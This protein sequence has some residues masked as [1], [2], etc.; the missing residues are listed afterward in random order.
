MRVGIEPKPISVL[1]LGLCIATGGWL[2]FS[3][4]QTPLQDEVSVRSNTYWPR[5]R[6]T[7]KVDSRLVEVGVVVR[8]R[9]GRTV[10]GLSRDNFA[11]IDAGKKREITAFSRETS[12]RA[13]SVIPRAQAATA[14]PAV[15]QAP[16]RFV[17]LLFDDLTI[18]A[19][20]LVQV[21]TAAL[22]FVREGLSAGDLLGIFTISKEQILPFTRNVPEMIE[23]IDKFNSSPRIPDGGICP[24]LTPY[25]AY[26]IA[27]KL[28]PLT[29]ELKTA[30]Y[31]RCRSFPD[32]RIR[33]AT[34]PTSA[35]GGDWVSNLAEVMWGQIY[36]LSRAALSTI[37]DI[38]EYLG[39][40]TGKRMILLASSGF[41][42]QTLEHEQD[43]IVRNALR[44]QVVINALDARGLY[45]QDPVESS[46][47]SDMQ[48][49]I[50]AASLGT[51]QKDRGKDAMANLALS[52][53]GLFFH[54]N[55]DLTLGFRELGVLPEVSYLL[56]YTPDEPLNGKYHKLKVSVKS[57]DRYSVQARPGY[58]AVA[59]PAQNLL[60][61]QRSIDQEFSGTD[62]KTEL[63]V[64][65]AEI[66]P[67]SENGKPALDV[68]LHIDVGRMDLDQAGDTRTRK[69]TWI[70]GL[71]D[72]AGNFIVGSENAIEMALK[73]PT[74][75][76]M[77]ANG[78]NITITLKA[79]PGNYQ[80]R[81]VV[82]D[83]LDGKMATSTLPVAIR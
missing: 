23:T 75:K 63:A 13:G 71:L 53:G 38:V 49:F 46:L 74:Y 7:L 78:L 60:N 1:C 4:T 17:A 24:R 37:E 30:E 52:T 58:W 3:R 44:R 62:A 54:N 18:G 15:T 9:K 11:I 22:R 42:A 47:G 41:L 55:N 51:R 6:Y 39:G 66:R 16:P 36:A 80:L 31:N 20:E 43:E 64:R 28:D 12:L 8:D 29:L 33:S 61:A 45:T 40:M 65:L 34:V 67:T 77:S 72:D 21:K 76:R 70:A 79:T 19:S 25:D 35:S 82:Q 27:N 68:V 56:G 5:L 26:V 57:K 48:S 83:G 32:P 81:S 50:R 59:N 10:G 69:L 73:E 2:S 14:E